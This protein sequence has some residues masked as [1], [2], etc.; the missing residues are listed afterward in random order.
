MKTKTLFFTLL[1]LLLFSMLIASCDSMS[2]SGYQGS[3][4][5][6]G[7]KGKPGEKGDP[8]DPGNV[9][10]SGDEDKVSFYAEQDFIFCSLS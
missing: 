10:I 5:E 3:Q 7:S 8:G 1:A 9:I 6:K 2:F 4:G